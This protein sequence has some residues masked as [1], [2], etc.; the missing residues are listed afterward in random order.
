[1]YL[2]CIF[3]RPE[4]RGQG[5]GKKLMQRVAAKARGENCINVQWQTP[6]FNTNAIKFYNHLG[7]ESKHK[8]RFF[9]DP[10]AMLSLTQKQ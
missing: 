7:A 1:M 10:P 9:L 3:L 5:I 2:D 6:V 4:T 8:L